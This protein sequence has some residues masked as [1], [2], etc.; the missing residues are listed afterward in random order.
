VV[1]EIYRGHTIVQRD[2]LIQRSS[3][4]RLAGLPCLHR[5]CP[6]GCTSFLE[7]SA[8]APENGNISAWRIPFFWPVAP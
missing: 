1:L 6:S 7:Q 2:A 3:D 5:R 8:A 4:K